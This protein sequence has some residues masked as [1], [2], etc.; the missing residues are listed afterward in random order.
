MDM[1]KV[2]DDFT[3]CVCRGRKKA[4]LMAA[5]REKDIHDLATF[6]ELENVGN[7]CG[8]CREDLMQLIDMVWAE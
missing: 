6:Q 3:V 2:K 4:E 1:T 7:K 5:I 8:G